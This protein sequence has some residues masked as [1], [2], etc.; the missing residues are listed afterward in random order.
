MSIPQ[1]KK[2]PADPLVCRP[3]LL[4]L[5]CDPGID[6]QNG[7]E[8]NSQYPFIDTEMRVVRGKSRGRILRIMGADIHVKARFLLCIK[9]EILRPHERLCAL[10]VDAESGQ[11]PAGTSG[12][13]FVVC[14]RRIPVVP[15][16]VTFAPECRTDRLRIHAEVSYS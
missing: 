12:Q 1:E 11:C 16:T 7:P 13:L 5:T 14:Q 9:R 8:C 15:D 4:V 10:S 3:L 6:A 2:W